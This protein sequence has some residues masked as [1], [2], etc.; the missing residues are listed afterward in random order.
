MTISAMDM[1]KEARSQIQCIDLLE[2]KKLIK[3]NSATLLDVRE[4]VEFD[5]GH[6]TGAQHIS[7]GVLEMM[8]EN[9]PAF[10]D[11][12]QTVLIYCKTGGRS[13]LATATLKKMG[14]TSLF[15]MDGGFDSWS[16]YQIVPEGI[17]D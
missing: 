8:I 12:N 2:A 1:I 14:F 17:K 10:K 13:A 3:D 11:K 9:H 4:K 5:A 16:K 6:I 7:R 15:S